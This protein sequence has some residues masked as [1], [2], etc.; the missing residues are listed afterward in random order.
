MV[1]AHPRQRA[2]DTPAERL[3]RMAEVC[4]RIT[5]RRDIDALPP[6][7]IDGARSL[8]NARYGAL[9]SSDDSGGIR[10][11]VT[12]GLTSE[13]RQRMGSLPKG[14]GL[15]GYL[16]QVPRTLRL[17]DI[18]SHPIPVGFPENHPPMKTFLGAP[19][20]YAGEPV[21]NIYL[22]E[23][24]D[25]LEFSPMTKTHSSYSLPKRPWS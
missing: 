11:I 19:I 22:T 1:K 2:N 10:D 7:T 21:G 13:E 23:R 17:S 18:A 6:E 15:L 25:G 3:S 20:R 24:R 8:T 9:V 14:L 12:S 5:S 16:N 4:H